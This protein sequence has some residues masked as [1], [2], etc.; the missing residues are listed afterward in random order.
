M[1]GAGRPVR[2]ADPRGAGAEHEHVRAARAAHPVVVVPSVSVE[3]VVVAP[4]PE[5]ELVPLPVPDPVP[6]PEPEPVPLP[7]V[8]VP[9]MFRTFEPSSSPPQPDTAS[10]SAAR[11]I[12]AIRFIHTPCKGCLTFTRW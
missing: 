7:D 12:V 4:V 3:S 1:A 8:V 10:A 11:A 5:P 2:G 6:L 9:P